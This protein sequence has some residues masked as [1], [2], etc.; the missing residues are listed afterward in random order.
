[1]KCPG[2]SP[3]HSF[4]AIPSSL[5]TLLGPRRTPAVTPPTGNTNSAISIFTSTGFQTLSN[6]AYVN[7]I[8]NLRPDIAI[9]LGD[10]PYGLDPGTKRMAKMGDRTIEWLTELLVQKDEDQSILAPVL[11]T[12]LQTQWE[13]LDRLADDVAD[14][15][16]G[17]AVYDSNILPDIPA[18][19][20]LSAL[21]RFSLDEPASPHKILRQISLGMDI[22]TIP[23]IGFATDAGIALSFRFPGPASEHS[24]IPTSTGISTLPLGIDM[25]NVEHATSLIPL[26]FSCHCYACTSHHRAFL[27]HLLSAKEMLGWVLLQVH[28]HEVLSNFFADIRASIIAGSF[29]ADC[30]TFARTYE[31]ELPEKSGQGPRVRGY[32]YKSE[33]P[34]E[35]KKNKRAWGFFSGDEKEGQNTTVL[36]QNVVSEGNEL[37]GTTDK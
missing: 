33:G 5:I 10:V 27:Q 37:A 1:M 12:D 8:K 31:S 32:H 4:S 30:L 7:Y 22:F 13:Y 14:Q 17:L 11:P 6:K 29:A 16:D 28:N 26:S 35:Q 18:T 24:D 15:V 9:A 36:D 19:T 2:T 20:N 23:F 25:W 3:F 34:F 21:P